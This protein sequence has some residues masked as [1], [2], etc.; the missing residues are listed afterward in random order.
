MLSNN[1]SNAQKQKFMFLATEAQKLYDFKRIK[2]E[3]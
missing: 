2:Q 3:Y 1:R